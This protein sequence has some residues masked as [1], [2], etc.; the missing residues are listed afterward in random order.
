MKKILVPCDFSFTATQAYS[1]ALQI[2][3]RTNAELHVLKVLDLPFSYESSYAAGHYSY[4]RHL[5]KTL[6]D[7]ARQS[8]EELKKRSGTTEKI[9]FSVLQGSVTDVIRTYI[10]N[11]GI[12]FVVMGTNGAT[13]FTEYLVGSNTEKIVRLSPVPVLAI[14]QA[15]ELSSITDIAVPTDAEVVYPGFISALKELQALFVAELHLLLVSTD[16]KLLNS[17]EMMKK[18]DDFA[19]RAGLQNYTI[20]LQREDRK[21]QGIIEFAKE[22]KADM[23]AMS[24]HGRQGLG[25]LFTGSLAE[26]IV[27]HVNC[28]VLTYSTRNESPQVSKSPAERSV[29]AAH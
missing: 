15:I 10:D 22:I 26:D 23:I 27:N 8:F 5:L 19:I 11:E 4:D 13:G 17:N 14:R 29:Q 6:E 21:E 18:L 12:D 7:D 28:P 20:N 3:R 16:S 2:A 24:T 1:V 9:H 25:H